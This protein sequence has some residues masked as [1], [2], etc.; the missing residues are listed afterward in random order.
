MR[1]FDCFLPMRPRQWLKNLMLFFP[2]FFCGA[3][4]DVSVLLRGIVPFIAFCSASGA[5]YIIND[6]V[7]REQDVLHPD[8][9]NRPIASGHVS[10]PLAKLLATINVAVA[11]I[12]SLLISMPFLFYLS[13][14]FLI[15]IFYSLKFKQLPI[16]DIFCVASGF[17]LRLLAGG[18]AFYVHISEWLFLLV[19]L[20]AIFLSAGK[21][22]GESRV[23]GKGARFHRSSL[24]RYPK[25]LLEG[26]LYLTGSAVLVTYIFF[27]LP[28]Y[29][30]VYTVPL[31]TFGLFRY[32]Y[33]VKSHLSGDPTDSLLGDLP[34]FITAVL[35]VVMVSWS[36]YR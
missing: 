27:S 24:K 26:I 5:M 9:R 6:L 28:R 14:Y 2:P 25:G 23:L 18:E 31:C 13:M 19:F 22:L 36:I 11:I 29:P 20:L 32:I 7:D 30:L 12:L 34:L 4:S 17:I 15:S 8:K 21:R 35:W 33:R 3:F 10:M 1:V 16:L